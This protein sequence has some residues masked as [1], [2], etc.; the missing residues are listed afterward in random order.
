MSNLSIKIKYSIPL[1][2]ALLALVFTMFSNRILIDDLEQSASVFPNNFMPSISEVLNAD[3]DLY[4]ARVAEIE[5]VHSENEGAKHIET[6]KENALQA[7][8]RFNQYLLLMKDYP[9]VLNKLKA[10]DRLYNQWF[11][12]VQQVISAKKNGDT[13]QAI[14]LMNNKSEQA[15]STLRD[16]YDV[17]GE[18]AFNK[19]RLLQTEIEQRN[20]SA[21]L[22]KF[23]L[24]LVTLIF[25]IFIAYFSQKMLLQRLQ[26]IKTGIDDITSG[27][28]DLTH[29]IEIKQ[30]D[31]I[32]DLGVAF[33]Q[34]VDSLKQLI[35][36]VRT[37]V[38]SLNGT[39]QTLIS[40]AA[41]GH[42]VAERQSGA[43]DMIVSAV[44]E[45]S[46]STKELAVIAQRTADETQDAM[47]RSQEGVSKIGASVAQVE[48][49][50][51]T[52]EGASDGTQKLSEDSKNISG[53][54]DVIRGIA[55]QTNLLALNAAIE[56]ARAGEQGRGFA[57]VAD[58]VRTLAQKTQESTDSI[59]GMIESLQGGVNDVVAQINDGFEKVTSTVTLSKETEDSLNM[60]LTS[61]TT[62]SDMSIQTAA[63]TEEQTAVTDDINQNLRQLNEQIQLANDVAAS[64][65][66][67]SMDVKSLAHNI[68]AGV[69]RFKVN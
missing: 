9:D 6:F 34:F 44:N 26:E 46:L 50:Y 58:E 39:S 68:D 22:A 24:T 32:G 2:L 12:S 62:V 52:I 37:D 16:L 21:K 18:S 31:E 43:S 3:R 15:F 67:A 42:D 49:L 13:S 5:Y 29:K 61:V 33:N 48:Q 69:S 23:S 40:S 55:E 47:E 57:V 54:L 11:E 65:N 27:G 36:E 10:F 38:E 56:A 64:T 60:I 1:F 30:Q 35:T 17:A 28:G 51:T 20:N 45:M 66:S 14:S 63:A 53:V 4:Q 25:T 19:A 8:D 59:Q 41:Q 7:K